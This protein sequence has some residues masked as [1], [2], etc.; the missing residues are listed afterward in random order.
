M[1]NLSQNLSQKEQKMH[2]RDLNYVSLDSK[3]FLTDEDFQIMS[4]EERGAYCSI[5]F[6]LYANNGVLSANPKILSK[7]CNCDSLNQFNKIWKTLH[8]KFY[9]RNKKLHHKK[10]SKELAR[11]SKLSQ[12][13]SI[14]GVKGNEVRWKSN[15][16][17]VAKEAVLQSQVTRSEAKRSEDK[18]REDISNRK[19]KSCFS[20]VFKKKV[21]QETTDDSIKIS[22][23]SSI[24]LDSREIKRKKLLTY[25]LLIRELQAKGPAN[26]STLRNFIN[27]VAGKVIAGHF[28][29]E[30][31]W[32]R[33]ADIAEQ[34][35]GKKIKNP[36]AIFISK[37]KSDLGYLKNE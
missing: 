7:L 17:T 28:D 3:K 15:R 31:I 13:R 1:K 18:K 16:K 14:A 34:S 20:D 32:H 22:S 12:I 19:H 33:I 27:W 25:D 6:N 11:A 24:R 30:K 5:I 8:R 4:I 23:S 9:K 21:F 36:P 2:K 35:R 26:A 29:N 10:V 37:V